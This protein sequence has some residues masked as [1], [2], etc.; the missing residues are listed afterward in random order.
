MKSIFI[1][2]EFSP[3]EVIIKLQSITLVL[4]AI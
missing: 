4:Y 2:D 3:Y 1:L